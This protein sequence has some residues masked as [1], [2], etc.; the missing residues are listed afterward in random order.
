MTRDAV[1][2]PDLRAW[3][4]ELDLVF[5]KI[6]RELSEVKNDNKVLLSKV[7]KLED[8]VNKTHSTAI[9]KQEA[10]LSKIKEENGRMVQKA[11]AREAVV[12]GRLLDLGEMC[13]TTLTKST[14]NV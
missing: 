6:V 12:R 10:S 4:G 13:K 3:V 8:L 14:K 1:H 7:E 2:T 9:K 11:E 5:T